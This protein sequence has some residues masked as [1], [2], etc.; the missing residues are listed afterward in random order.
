MTRLRTA[1]RA[2]FARH[3]VGPVPTGCADLTISHLD[4][5]DGIKESA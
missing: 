1:L 3:I 2:W 5:L 4:R